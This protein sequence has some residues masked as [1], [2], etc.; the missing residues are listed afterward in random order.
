MNVSGLGQGVLSNQLQRLDEIERE[1]R[2]ALPQQPPPGTPANLDRVEISPLAKTSVT[3]TPPDEKPQL[4]RRFSEEIEAGIN[5]IAITI[6]NARFTEATGSLMETQRAGIINEP[7]KGLMEKDLARIKED[8]QR[9]LAERQQQQASQSITSPSGA[10]L[11]AIIE[12]ISGEQLTRGQ[13]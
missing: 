10:S 3:A 12:R 1:F 6:K 9:A 11:N 8:E 13:Q 7:E 4:F 2:A 5:N